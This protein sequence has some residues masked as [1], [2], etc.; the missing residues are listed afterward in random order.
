MAGLLANGGKPLGKL[1]GPFFTN[2]D[3]RN[4]YPCTDESAKNA[5]REDLMQEKIST[6]GVIGRLD[7]TN[8]NPDTNPNDETLV[9]EAAVV[10]KTFPRRDAK[11][12]FIGE[13]LIL[14]TPE[15]QRL[16]A[17]CKSGKKPGISYRGGIDQEAYERGDTEA[18]WKQFTIEGFD[19]VYVPAYRECY[20]ELV[21]DYL[22]PDSSKEPI[23]TAAGRKAGI[24]AQGAARAMLKVA[25]SKQGA[26][27]MA[28][29]MAQEKHFTEAEAL[30]INKAIDEA[31]IDGDRRTKEQA[32]ELGTPYDASPK[33]TWARQEGNGTLDMHHEEGIYGEKDIDPVTG[34]KIETLNTG[35]KTEKDIPVVGRQ[36]KE[37]KKEAEASVDKT[38]KKIKDLAEETAEELVAEEIKKKKTDKSASAEKGKY[39]K[40]DD[41][42][43]IIDNKYITY[44]NEG[45]VVYKIVDGYPRGGV[46]IPQYVFETIKTIKNNK[47]EVKSGV[48]KGTVADKEK[49]EDEQLKGYVD[50]NGKVVKKNASAIEDVD[51]LYYLDYFESHI[52]QGTID[53]VDIGNI[54]KDA[55]FDD[56]LQNINL[57]KMDL[58][59]DLELSQYLAE[60]T[61]TGYS[62]WGEYQGGIDCNLAEKIFIAIL[63]SIENRQAL[64]KASNKVKAGVLGVASEEETPEEK[65]KKG[66]LGKDGKV[67]KRDDKLSRKTKSAITRTKASSL[68]VKAEEDDPEVELLTE[69]GIKELGSEIVKDESEEDNNSNSD[70]M[71]KLV[72][73]IATLTE[74]IADLKEVVKGKDEEISTRNSELDALAANYKRLKGTVASAVDRARFVETVQAEN[75]DLQERN[76]NLAKVLVQIKSENKARVAELIAE[77]E[78]YEKVIAGYERESNA[79]NRAM[80]VQASALRKKETDNKV[81]A[82][83][84][85]NLGKLCIGMVSEMLGIDEG[86]LLAQ[87]GE[88]KSKAQLE[89]VIASLQKPKRMISASYYPITEGM[90]NA[91]P[92]EI[93][94]ACLKA[95]WGEEEEID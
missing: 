28:K 71:Q 5:E 58:E 39:S 10:M 35:N 94:D 49:D 1:R 68:G 84:N 24:D 93:Q 9:K 57:I 80:A 11:G 4:D 6:G 33:H 78:G 41:G 76:A 51:D 46:D 83:K 85:D 26:K 17:Y 27:E 48:E 70:T 74:E 52:I 73:Q 59:S 79:R 32:K 90:Q 47:S 55:G 60:E 14:D 3:N 95:D 40:Q 7:H 77:K 56:S 22:D 91:L 13:C 43:I 36:T 23:K 63:E 65:E 19:I 8:Q 64:L 67:I 12:R 45:W 16:Y 86:K 88:I 30:E 53:S 69:D 29:V 42:S 2:G 37:Q 62:F 72:E 82:G 34:K 38:E 44:P 89:K 18:A 54:L 20:L 21:E 50:K 61:K 31:N 81:L 15:G 25:A 87:R 92:F 66:E 75:S